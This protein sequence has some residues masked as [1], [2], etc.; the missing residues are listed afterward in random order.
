MNKKYNKDEMVES[1]K[2]YDNYFKTTRSKRSMY[3]ISTAINGFVMNNDLVNP[4][5]YLL[6]L[7]ADKN[8]K[9]IKNGKDYIMT[10]EL[11]VKMEQDLYLFQPENYT[12][13]VNH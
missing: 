13:S 11:G 10:Y 12:Q 2:H 7:I 3:I 5:H 1:I 6:Y 8:L 4:D 9:T